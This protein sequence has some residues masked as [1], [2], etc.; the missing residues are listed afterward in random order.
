MLG[1][2]AVPV[3]AAV[4]GGMTHSHRGGPLVAGVA[5]MLAWGVLLAVDAWLGPLSRVASL[6]GG[7]LQ[8]RPI[9]VYVV[10][11]AFPGLL[12]VSAAL[13]ARAATRGVAA[14]WR[15]G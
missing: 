5:A 10:T 11:L 15:E 6:V 7:V 9:A 13:V 4:Y 8:V 14:R 3:A 2:W 1:W 12:A